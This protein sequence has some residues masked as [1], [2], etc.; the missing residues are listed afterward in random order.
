MCSVQACN[1]RVLSVVVIPMAP[2]PTVPVASIHFQT[3]THNLHVQNVDCVLLVSMTP[4]VHGMNLLG[5]VAM[6]IQVLIHN[7]VFY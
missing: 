6:I 3:L 1:M 5:F 4:V 2:V 7:F